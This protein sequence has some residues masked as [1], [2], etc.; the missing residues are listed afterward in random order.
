MNISN[1]LPTMNRVTL[2]V[3]GA[4]LLEPV[5]YHRGYHTYAAGMLCT[6]IVF[7]ALPVAALIG[8]GFVLGRY[9]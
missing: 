3:R 6:Q 9:L 5:P 8:L 7:V 4:L 1:S 2:F